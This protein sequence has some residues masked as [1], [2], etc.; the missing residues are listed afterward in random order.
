MKIKTRESLRDI[1]V[2][3]KTKDLS[4]RTKRGIGELS[5]NT[6]SSQSSSAND[7]ASN[8][9]SEKA[10]R[11]GKS[12]T[13]AADRAGQISVRETQKNISNLKNRPHKVKK[14]KTK[15]N[16]PKRLKSAGKNTVKAS[17]RVKQTVKRL[18]K[19]I[20]KA[21]K[22]VVSAVK[23]MIA[24][25]KSI[26]AAIVAGCWVA[27]VVILVICLVA[28]IAGSVYAIFLPPAEDSGMTLQGT[29]NMIENEHYE[30]RDQMISEYDYDVIHY[31]GEIAPWKEII[32]VYAVKLNLDTEN[33]TELATFDEEK[34]DALRQVFWDMNHIQIHTEVVDEVRITTFVDENGNVSTVE[35]VVE[36][37]HLYVNTEITSIVK[38]CEIYSFTELQ[39]DVLDD[40]LS[41]ESAIMWGG[42]LFAE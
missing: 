19:G 4:E 31:N 6:E 20:V 40:L 5:K 22:A 25:T 36:I 35:T 23:V 9:V 41:E 7:Y 30:T 34:A 26:I 16:I 14:P 38:L 8:F 39:C 12:S 2:F 33:P 37:V 29:V 42:L 21:A 3:D 1:R 27:V 28:A 18:S 15:A 11:I 13:Y 17:E 32:A 24:A 10:E